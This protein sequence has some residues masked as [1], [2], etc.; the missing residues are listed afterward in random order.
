[1]SIILTCF[2]KS[3][4]QPNMAKQDHFLKFVTYWLILWFD[5]HNQRKKKVHENKLIFPSKAF[6]FYFL[7]TLPN[8][9]GRKPQK[10]IPWRIINRWEI[11]FW[12]ILCAWESVALSKTN[13][14]KQ[15]VKKKPIS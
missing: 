10:A 1:M 5:N 7:D 13:K 12:S 14:N 15:V 2:I 9:L 3:A 6:I 4:Y 8:I 11:F